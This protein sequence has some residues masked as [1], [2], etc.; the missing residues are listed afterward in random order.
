MKVDEPP[1]AVEEEL[2][3]LP[4]TLPGHLHLKGVLEYSNFETRP[5]PPSSGDLEEKEGSS[6]A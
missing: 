3:Q 1:R 6:K 5:D 4:F 2:R